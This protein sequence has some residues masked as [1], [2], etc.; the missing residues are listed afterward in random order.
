[1]FE[2]LHFRPQEVHKHG[3]FLKVSSSIE[4]VLDKDYVEHE[5]VEEVLKGLT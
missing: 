4:G 5:Q 3:H 2:D 1:M